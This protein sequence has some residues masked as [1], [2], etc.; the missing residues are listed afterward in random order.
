LTANPIKQVQ[1][2]Q[3]GCIASFNEKLRDD[4]PGLT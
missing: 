3:K 4:F 2:M 1:P